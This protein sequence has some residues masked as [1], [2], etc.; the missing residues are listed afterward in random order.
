MS[1]SVRN[2]TVTSARRVYPALTPA[3][4]LVALLAGCTVGP[5]FK[6]PDA[7]VASGYTEGPALRSTVAADG[8]VQTIDGE[9]RLPADWWHLFDCPALDGLVRQGLA[10]SPSLAATEA[11]L[12]QAQDTLKAGEGIFW[13]QVDAGADMARQRESR[14]A[15]GGARQ[16]AFN[17]FT[18]SASVSYA[19]DIFGG[20]HRRVEGLAAQVDYQRNAMRA[21]AL[22]LATT[23]V[24]TAIA[25]AA[26]DAQI[27]A[28]VAIV[29]L[30]REQVRLAIVHATAGTAGQAAV[31]SLR[32]QLE[33]TEASL[34]GLRQKQAQARHLMAV[35]VGRLPADW[36]PPFLSFSELTLPRS[37]PLSLPS[38]LVRQRPDI[39]QAE[40]ALHAA[41]AAIGVAT[42]ALLPSV[43]LDGSFGV[44]STSSD[45][46]FQAGSGV[47]SVGAGVAQPIFNGGALSYQRQAAIDA[48]DA[49]AA[50]Y[51]QTV[52]NAFQQ[53]ADV[54]RALEH[55]AES[56]ALLE[57]AE[58][59]AGAALALTQANFAAGLAA[60]ADVLVADVQYRTAKLSV[61]AA[62]ASRYQDTVALFAALGGGWWNAPAADH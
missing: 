28:T 38:A 5:D 24:D 49:A 48:Y 40:S 22:T 7:P 12:R 50:A 16:G 59:T 42:A 31:L 8:T 29:A 54:L 51:R 56:L 3:V 57:Q 14:N 25:S 55:D 33:A 4:A 60:Q 10:D 21:A 27:E 61:I 18:L 34:P 47:W 15:A 6:A 32:A 53:V 30:E 9:A 44:S 37:L 13:P 2:N 35:L 45:T 52:L 39:L 43:T 41:S 23:L 46:L 26:Y 20:E 19:L 62:R 1:I 58:K 36:Q 17:L 11:T